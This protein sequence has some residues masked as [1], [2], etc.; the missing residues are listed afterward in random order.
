MNQTRTTDHTAGGEGHTQAPDRSGSQQNNPYSDMNSTGK[1][2]G[3]PKMHKNK[4]KMNIRSVRIQ[5]GTLGRPPKS[6]QS[7][8]ASKNQGLISGT[9]SI[10]N[11]IQNQVSGGTLNPQGNNGLGF[12]AVDIG[13]MGIKIDQLMTNPNFLSNFRSNFQAT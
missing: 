10:S 13:S 5:P 6:K 3:F 11:I 7:V 1:V 4:S 2:G 8:R 12:S 9:P